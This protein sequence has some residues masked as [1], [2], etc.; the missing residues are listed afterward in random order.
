MNVF[1]K[2]IFKD[3]Q[4]FKKKKLHI[5]ELDEYYFHVYVISFL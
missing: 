4:I 1:L 3:I 5:H 2:F